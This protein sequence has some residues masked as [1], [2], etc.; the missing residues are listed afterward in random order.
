MQVSLRGKKN[1]GIFFCRSSSSYCHVLFLFFSQFRQT[2]W[3]QD[4]CGDSKTI[5][6]ER[7]EIDENREISQ[8]IYQL[9]IFFIS[10]YHCIIYIIVWGAK[11]LLNWI[12]S[13]ISSH[14]YLYFIILK[15]CRTIFAQCSYNIY[16][17]K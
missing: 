7:Y 6:F 13:V 11:I 17:L 9:A 3:I 5:L 16:F 15:E 12:F 2:G 10:L 1:P 4:F 8:D 14:F